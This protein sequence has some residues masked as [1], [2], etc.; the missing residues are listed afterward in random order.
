MTMLERE[1]ESGKKVVLASPKVSVQLFF[2]LILLLR[3]F[4]LFSPQVIIIS[5]DFV[6]NN[7]WRRL[8]P[9]LHSLWRTLTI[10]NESIECLSMPLFGHRK[11]KHRITL[12]TFVRW[13]CVALHTW[14]DSFDLTISPWEKKVEKSPSPPG[15]F[16]VEEENAILVVKV[17]KR[18]IGGE[19]GVKIWGD[20]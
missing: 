15:N 18:E 1:R 9:S 12:C 3:T 8:T 2:F 13:L 16:P 5:K 10:E 6:R 17:I 19:G 11:W 7:H 14:S 20:F 4:S